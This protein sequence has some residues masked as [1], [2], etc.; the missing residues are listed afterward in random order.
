MHLMASVKGIEEEEV[1]TGTL[2]TEEAAAAA[3]TS[4]GPGPIS[5]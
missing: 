3:A 4:T 2:V 1:A 5:F